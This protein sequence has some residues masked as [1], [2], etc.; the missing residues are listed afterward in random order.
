MLRHHLTQDTQ[1]IFENFSMQAFSPDERANYTTLVSAL[2][3]WLGEKHFPK[4]Y[5]TGFQISWLK[6]DDDI[7]TFIFYLDRL[8]RLVYSE[9]THEIQDE[10]AYSHFRVKSNLIIIVLVAHLNYFRSIGT[11]DDSFKRFQ[12]IHLFFIGFGGATVG[13]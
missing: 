5:Y 13:L 6:K 11:I 1:G 9:C 2:T 7:C 4:L 12:W 8:V 3:L 10:I